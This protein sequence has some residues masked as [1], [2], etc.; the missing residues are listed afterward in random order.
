MIDWAAA[1]VFDYLIIPQDDTVDYGW[2]IAESRR[3]RRAVSRLARAE[4]GLDLPRHGRDGD[5]AAGALCGAARRLRPARAAA[6]QR[7]HG[8]RVIT[9]YED[10]PMT[11][12][13]KAHLGPLAGT[14]CD[15]PDADLVLYV[16]APPKC[17]ATGRI[18]G[19]WRCAMSRSAALPATAQQRWPPIASRAAIARRRCARCSP[20]AATC[21]SSCAA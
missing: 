18:S 10:R 19:R 11:E 16:N 13:V 15:A 17:R 21:R 6:L 7:R 12:M 14:V 1:G 3:L 8:D 20:C 9:A 4:R 5:A 2:N